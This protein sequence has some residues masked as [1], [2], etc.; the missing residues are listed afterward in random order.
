MGCKNCY[1]IRIGDQ[2][3]ILDSRWCPILHVCYVEK[4]VG[5][6]LFCAEEGCRDYFS[7]PMNDI[8][9][10]LFTSFEA[11]QHVRNKLLE[12]IFGPVTR[13]LQENNIKF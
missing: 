8:G 9:D 12:D 4:I 1:P 7:V 10:T 5:D 13:H 11:M 6:R 3:Y 2:V